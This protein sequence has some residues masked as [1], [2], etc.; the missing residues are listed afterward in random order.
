ME[1]ERQHPAITLAVLC[2]AGLSFALLQ[3]MV[4]P[5]LPDIQHTLHTSESSVAW[6]LTAYLLSA[7]VATPIIGRLGDV[8]GKEK[9]M[10]VVLAVLAFGTL[11]SA[12]ATSIGTMIL[13]RIIQGAGGGIFPSPSASSATSFR[14]SASPGASA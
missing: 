6:I 13:G 2:I 8:H 12:L 5:A 11:I 4:A 14:L 9:S 7:S 10:L 3:S 1:A